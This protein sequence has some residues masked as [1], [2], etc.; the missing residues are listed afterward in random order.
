[1]RRQR[2]N[3]QQHSQSCSNNR[4]TCSHRV[5]LLLSSGSIAA[6]AIARRAGGDADQR[7]RK[8]PAVRCSRT[9]LA[10]PHKNRQLPLKARDPVDAGY[11]QACSCAGVRRRK[12]CRV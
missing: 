4:Q 7:A 3:S 5:I 2:R 8:G 10:F 6:T 12:R 9:T 11:E 1:M